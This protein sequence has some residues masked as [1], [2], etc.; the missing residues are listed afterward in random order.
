MLSFPIW[1]PSSSRVRICTFTRVR[2]GTKSSEAGDREVFR[3]YGDVLKGPFCRLGV[4][5]TSAVAFVDFGDRFCLGIV[6]KSVTE[7]YLEGLIIIGGGV[8]VQ[9]AD[10]GKVGGDLC[11]K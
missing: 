10:K 11:R 8:R 9:V 6:I 5:G 4:W 2:G 1:S 3:K 7:Y